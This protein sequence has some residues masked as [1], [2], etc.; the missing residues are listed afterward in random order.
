MKN[1]YLL[2][3]TFVL[4][5]YSFSQ[6]KKIDSLKNNITLK[7]NVNKK[8]QSLYE[9][10]EIYRLNIQNDSTYKYAHQGFEII[11]NKKQDSLFLLSTLQL[12][13]LS[14]KTAQPDT[15]NYLDLAYQISKS[16]NKQTLFIETYYTQ[17]LSHFYGVGEY[18]EA[19][20]YFLK[21]DS[22]S[23]KFNIKNKTTISALIQ[24]AEISR[25]KFT[26]RNTLIAKRILDE[27][28]KDART[29]KSEEMIYLVYTYL[30]DVSQLMKKYDDAKKYLKSASDYFLK[31]DDIRNVSQIYLLYTAYYLGI[32][33]LENAKKEQLKRISYLRKKDDVLELGRALMYSGSFHRR[34]TKDYKKAIE[35]LLEAKNI[36]E[37]LNMIDGDPYER[38]IYGLAL[39]YSEIKNHEESNSYYNLA[40]DLR[41]KLIKKEN[42]NLTTSLE[43]KYQNEKKEQEIKLLS[44]ENQLAKKQKYIYISIAILLLI[45]G[46]FLF[47]NYRNKIK[48]AEKLKE[49]NALK[50]RFFANISHE[51]RTPLTL[52]KS[53]VQSL[54]S[55]L[56]NEDDLSKLELID[57]NSNRMLELVDQLLEL[58]KI[59][60]GQLKLLFKEANIQQTLHAIVEPFVFEAKETKKIF[61]FLLPEV[62]INHVF[63]KDVIEKIITNLLS[64]A[65]KYTNPNDTISFNSNINN[66]TLEIT[67]SNSCNNLKQEDLPKLSERFYQKND[68]FDGAGIGLSLVKELITL[69]QGTIKT[70]LKDNMLS[71]VIHL[72]LKT[73]NPNAVVV[74][75]E[76]TSDN[77]EDIFSTDSELPILLIVDDN[78]D[79]RNL[80]KSLFEKN[81]VVLLAENAEEGFKLAKKHIPDCI[82]SDVMMPKTDGFEFT[83][84]I[85]T[86]ELT[87]FIPVILLTAKTS[88]TARLEGLKNQADAF[89]T[90]PF[91]NDV[92]M[93]T[94]L[95]LIKERKK[96]QE[97][98]SQEL[99]L[100][101]TDIVVDSY[102][103]KFT[104]KLQDILDANINKADFT[105]EEFSNLANLSRMQL[106][107]KLKTLFGVT[108]SEFIRNE[109]VK[110]ASELLKNRNISISEVGYAVGFNDISYFAKCFK[111]V[112]NVTPTEYQK[113]PS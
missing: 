54:K 43:A 48:T 44:A 47:F 99:V 81:Y 40:Y 79:I 57:K 24:R 5:F 45:S 63:D 110:M 28:L 80:L 77:L 82:I 46:V 18:A 91:N 72:P 112:F 26:E 74:S 68:S 27:A 11:K 32:N 62:S 100:K 37:N 67:V 104:A 23:K 4:S 98:Y 94:V 102:D 88:E 16:S 58:S 86:N 41:V 6:N 49:L 59:D 103:E 21:V 105:A 89:L 50:S 13:R 78:Q 61:K 71:F 113:T 2:A 65:F 56:S 75:K 10:A 66:E 20:P 35:S 8:W 96:L 15:I 55:S 22:I 19:M 107:R 29:I 87:S 33:D 30:S 73:E 1:L 111:D 70:T 52:I 12:Y 64:N 93:Q 53:P 39:C 38:I 108:T 92:V 90:K 69:Y 7:S 95:Q 31:K 106:H 51:F 83:N 14:N 42:R 17:G 101:P 97:R 9:L 3:I 60:N 25:L 85:K 36:Y 109:R 76:T 84:T 34:K